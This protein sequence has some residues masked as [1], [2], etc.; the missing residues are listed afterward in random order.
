MLH[1]RHF[2]ATPEE[3]SPALGSGVSLERIRE[4]MSADP[5]FLRVTRRTW[6]LRIWDL[7]A[8]AGISGEIGARID[9]AGGRINTRELITMLRAE[10]PDVA[11]SSIRTHLTDSLAFIS[12]GATVRRRTADDPWPPV[13]PLR[14]ARGAYRN[15][16]NEIRLALPVKPDLLRGSG[17][18]LHPAVA[19]ALGLSPDERREFDSAQGPVAVLWRLVST[20]GPMI[21]SLRAQ[22]RA[23]NAQGLDTL[24]L[25]FTLDNASL[26]VER[27]GADVTGLARLRRLLGRPVRTPEAAL[28]TSLDCPRKD[29]AAV[30]RRRG[31]EDIAALLKS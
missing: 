10:I 9:A 23:V 21:A 15:G 26:T 18:S 30:L 29:V 17:Q 14:A 6:G 12:D 24:L 3:I 22:A 8:H 2:P 1:A 27:L 13:P 5:R 20:N 31:D 11:E 25:I 16:A 19:A 28:A 4:A 7:P